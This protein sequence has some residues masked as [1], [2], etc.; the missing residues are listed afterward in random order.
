M[1]EVLGGAL[2]GV[3]GE[4]VAELRGECL[5]LMSERGVG[6]FDTPLS[7]PRRDESRSV[8]GRT[9]YSCRS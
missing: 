9:K 8:N 7:L 4:G 2:V 5:S 3:R 6:L 1:I